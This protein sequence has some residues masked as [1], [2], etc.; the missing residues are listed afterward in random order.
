MNSRYKYQ[1]ICSYNASE[2]FENDKTKDGFDKIICIPK[3][4]D[5]NGNEI[6]IKFNKIYNDKNKNDSDLF[7]CSRI[8]K[9]EKDEYI[10]EKFCNME[11]N[12]PS[13]INY[14][15]DFLFIFYYADHFLSKRLYKD[16]AKNIIEVVR[17]I[18]SLHDKE[19]SDT[20]YDESNS[21]NSSFN[22]EETTNI[23]L[24]NHT[25]SNVDVNIKDY[26][27]KEEK[28]KLE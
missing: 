25:V 10:K 24:E 28:R 1:Y 20:E 21:N 7:Y 8:D 9:P 4:N 2:N 11:N 19:E 17:Y 26:I 3:I 22:E 5:I 27:E 6:I 18:N 15:F 14:L 13:I 23:I 12:L 16:L